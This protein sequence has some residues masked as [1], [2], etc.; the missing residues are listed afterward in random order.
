MACRMR[1]AVSGEQTF[2]CPLTKLDTVV[3]ETPARAATS[4]M[5]ALRNWRMVSSKDAYTLY[6]NVLVKHFGR[7]II[8]LL[9]RGVKHFF[10]GEWDT[11]AR[12]GGVPGGA[13]TFRPA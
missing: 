1:S 12:R 6:R 4:L 5:V 13:Q 11:S 10:R 3:V 9:F 2:L 7:G 8:T